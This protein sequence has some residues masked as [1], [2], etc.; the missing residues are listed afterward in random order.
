MF[1]V[2]FLSRKKMVLKI[3]TKQQIF[4]HNKLESVL[5]PSKMMKPSVNS[6]AAHWLGHLPHC[7]TT[8]VN[9]E[10]TQLKERT[11]SCILRLPL[12]RVWCSRVR[13]YKQLLHLTVTAKLRVTG[14]F[15]GTQFCKYIS[16]FSFF[17]LQTRIQF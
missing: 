8:W 3:K 5:Q 16:E 11:N 4:R 12:G 2:K 15:T 17:F 10:P 9:A 7:L 13:V 1:L 6:V 14:D